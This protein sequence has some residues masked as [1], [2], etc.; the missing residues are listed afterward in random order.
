MP[1]SA[2]R[3][4]HVAHETQRVAKAVR[5]LG[6]VGLGAHH[7]Q[8]AGGVAGV[9]A[10][11][12]D[13]GV[14]RF[15]RGGGQRHARDRAVAHLDLLQVVGR[16]L[17]QLDAAPAQPG[18]Q[19]QLQPLAHVARGQQRARTEGGP[20]GEQA[21]AQAGWFLVVG[22]RRRQA[23]VGVVP[24]ELEADVLVRGERGGQGQVVAE[25]GGHGGSRGGAAGCG[26]KA[27]LRPGGSTREPPARREL[28]VSSHPA[29]SPGEP[30][31]A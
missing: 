26:M 4:L 3:R 1:P 18:V 19:A 28:G 13:R 8:V 23:V 11:A 17:H 12:V 22:R 7:R 31:T 25:F 29:G 10:H 30:P 5:R 2:A 21:V 6:V 20:A 9:V 16:D 14:S 27:V 15:E 24:A